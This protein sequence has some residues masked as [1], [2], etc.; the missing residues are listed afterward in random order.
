MK[1]VLDDVPTG[2]ALH[3]RRSSTLAAFAY[4]QIAIA[5]GEMF[6]FVGARPHPVTDQ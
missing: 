3:N 4:E 2:D 6:Q 5:N 1:C